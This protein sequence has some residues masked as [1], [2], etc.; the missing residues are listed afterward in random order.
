MKL[1]EPEI[2]AYLSTFARTTAWM[3]AAPL[4]GERALPAKIGVAAAAVI[5][6]PLAMVRHSHG[7]GELVG[8]LPNEVLFGLLAGFAA[9]LALAGAEAGGQ[10]IGVQLE[11]NFAGT[12]DPMAKEETLPTRKI[13]AALATTAFLSTGGLERAIAALAYPVGD[14]ALASGRL[15]AF[16]DGG[17][18]VLAL[19]LRVAAPLVAAAVVSNLAVAL[20]SRAAPALNVFSVMLACILVVGALVLTASAPSFVNELLGDA[21]LAA[22][23][24]LDLARR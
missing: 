24:A 16:V 20:A 5:A 14:V 23:A 3:L 18:Q 21:R 12:M 15:S 6:L 22:D 19:G 17:G 13:A 11:L 7:F 1:G 2:A 10:L 8:Q 4:T 9:R